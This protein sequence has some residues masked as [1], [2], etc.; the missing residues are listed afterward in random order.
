M[1]AATLVLEDNDSLPDV[2][3]VMDEIMT[4]EEATEVESFAERWVIEDPVRELLAVLSGSGRTREA[5][6]ISRILEDRE[7]AS[8]LRVA[9]LLM[10]SSLAEDW[11]SEE[12]AIYDTL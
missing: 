11:D 9:Q 1:S 8:D 12:D 7:D 3:F 4:A 5:M 6:V 2:W 10:Q